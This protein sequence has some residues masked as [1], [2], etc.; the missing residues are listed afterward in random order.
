MKA[1]CA[2]SAAMLILLTLPSVVCAVE[3]EVLFDGSATEKWDTAR[4][5]A[6]LSREFSQS[7]LAPRGNPPA[8]RWRF[9][10]KE[11]AFNDIFL[12]KPLAHPFTTVRVRLR[13]QGEA[14]TLAAKVGDARG[15]EWTT[16]RIELRQGEDWHWVE[17]PIGQ[18]ELAPW[19]SVR[20]ARMDFPL[21]YFTLI[22]FQVHAG[23][24]YELQ[25]ARVEVLRPDPA[26]LT[27]HGLELASR[28]VHGRTYPVNLSLQLDKPV[29]ADLAWL[30]FRRGSLE[31]FRR[32]VALPTSPRR[33]KPG[34]RIGVGDARIAVPEYAS[35]GPYEVTLELGEAKVLWKGRPMETSPYPVEIEA[36]TPERSAAS[37]HAHHGVPTLFVNGKPHSGMAYAAYE[38]SVEV[39]RDFSQAGVDLFTFAA[40][41]TESG[42]GLSRTAWTAAGQFDFSQLDERVRMV[43]EANPRAYFFPRLYLHAPTWWS[44]AHP[45]DLVLLDPGDG[46][47]VPLMHAGDKPAPS[48]ASPT[49]RKDT[50]EGLRRLIAHVE[51]APYADRC[52]GYHI[53]SGTTEE[54]MM[55]GANEDQWVDYSPVNTAAFRL[56]L[57]AKYG[58]VDNLRRAWNAPVA[59]FEAVTIPAKVQRQRTELGALRDPAKEQA[60]VDF[61]LY[62]SDLVAETICYFAKAIKEIT[63]REKIVGAFYGY[64]LQLCGEQRQQNAGHLALEKVLGSPDVDFVCSPTSYRFRQLGGEGTSHFM[65]LL[66]SVRL[67]GKLWFDEN[68]IRTSLSPGSVGEWGRPENVAGDIIQQEKELANV[69]TNG[70]A[71]WWFDVGRNR[72]DDPALMRRIGQLTASASEALDIQR[73]PADEV[74]MVV[75]EKSLCYL[76][77]SDPLGAWLLVQQLP[78]LQRIGSPVGHYLASDLPR[79]ADRKVFL[80]MTSFA[81]TAADRAAI[82]ALKKDNHVLVFFYAPGL[83]RDGKLDEAAMQELTG[84]RLRMT[85]TPTELR[86]SLR[87]GHPVT[88]GLGGVTYGVPHKTFPVCFAEDPAATVLGTLPDGR[89]GLVIKPH[90]GWAAVFSAVPMLPASLFRRIARLGN[91]HEYV[92]TEDVVWASRDM[93]AICVREQGLRKIA[94]PRRATVRDFYTGQEL[95]RSTEAFEVKFDARATRVFRLGKGE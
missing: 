74:A 73:S 19:S 34:E 41:P 49:W 88:Q 62:N 77:P 33:W 59:S 14:F 7:E 28:L 71:Q 45:N 67:H 52:I 35:G 31:M 16:R 10:P 43:L 55:W 87:P 6:R 39:F 27:V 22:A 46:K 25:V 13:N 91:V 38:P 69:M 56:W 12:R 32:K 36:R 54:W 64:L 84:I 30:V 11:A 70:T 75:D 2:R 23:A 5:E 80:F 29:D 61:Y 93:L 94:L 66:G 44:R 3:T 82:Q 53:A 92:R 51:A 81:P 90:Q 57:R 68:D 76:R 47:P 60:V 83:Y 86:L 78:A 72:Y 21:A 9:V 65:S 24:E 95:A 8:L 89:A 50:V 42:Y 85:T 18:W 15:A 20:A 58:T 40:T 1:K 4:D 17:F 48:W 79:I 63:G 37:V 26:V